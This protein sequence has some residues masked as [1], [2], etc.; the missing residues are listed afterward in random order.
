MIESFNNIKKNLTNCVNA[1]KSDDQIKQHY[2]ELIAKLDKV[3]HNDSTQINQL[4][5]Q[6]AP[7]MQDC[8]T[9][10]KTIKNKDWFWH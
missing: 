6:Y 3:N 9:R 5:D 8:Q 7:I 10:M 1:I 2:K 4:Y